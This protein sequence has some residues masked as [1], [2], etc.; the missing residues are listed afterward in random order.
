M[1]DVAI[2]GGGHNGL[3]TAAYLAKAGLKV[4]VFE[5]REIVG[6]ASIT[7]ELWPGI[8]VSTGAYVLSL[9]RPKI[10][11]ELKLREF[12]LKVYLKD[13]GLFLPFENG[14]KLYVWL[15]LEKLRKK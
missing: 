3:V 4:A 2:I 9:L 10:I 14:K 6:G 11:E 12:G 1:I 15:S 8:K 7:E 13:P 5:R